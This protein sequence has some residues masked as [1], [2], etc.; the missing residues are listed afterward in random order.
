VLAAVFGLDSSTIARQVQ[1]LERSGLALRER[2]P[3][4]GR[5]C[6]LRL[7]A[8]GRDVLRQTR[9]HRRA[10]LQ[11]AL[12]NWPEADLDEFGRLLQEFN[13]SMHRLPEEH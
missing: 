5:A 8:Q 4:D 11:K 3:S 9:K 13:A 12:V 10:R 1:D 7:T 6:V 2:D